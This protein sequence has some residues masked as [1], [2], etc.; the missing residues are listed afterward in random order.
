MAASGHKRSTTRSNDKARTSPEQLPKLTSSLILFPSTI[1]YPS[2][3]AYIFQDGGRIPSDVEIAPVSRREPPAPTAPPST[4]S[5]AVMRDADTSPR[6][7]K[8]PA[9][10]HSRVH[11]QQFCSSWWLPRLRP[12]PYDLLLKPADP[13]RQHGRAVCPTADGVDC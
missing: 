2:P 3:Q 6:D 9:K 4:I 12:R 13:S 1:P 7:L 8:F 5:F 10:S 11:L